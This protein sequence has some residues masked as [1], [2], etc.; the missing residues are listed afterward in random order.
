[1]VD[2]GVLH[3]HSLATNPLGPSFDGSRRLRPLD[4]GALNHDLCS[5]LP[6]PTA[7]IKG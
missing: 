2:L 1:M 6:A 7:P 5:L 3:Q 4:D